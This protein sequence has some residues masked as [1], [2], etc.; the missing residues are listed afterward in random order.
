ML[1]DEWREVTP[2]EFKTAR[3]YTQRILEDFYDDRP[4]VE[5]KLKEKGRLTDKGNLQQNRKQSDLPEPSLRL[6]PERPGRL[7][8]RYC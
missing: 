3:H 5:A 4:L 1:H 6:E 8:Q 7:S 2:E